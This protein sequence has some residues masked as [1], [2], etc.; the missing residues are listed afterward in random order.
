MRIAVIGAGALGTFFAA[1]LAGAGHDVGM[2]A[3][4]ARLDSIRRDGLQLAGSNP[5]HVPA[6]ADL[7]ALPSPD[8]VLIATKTPALA[9]AIA[10]QVHCNA[11]ANA[12]LTV[13]NGV[14]APDQVAAAL[15]QAAVLAGRVHGFFELEQDVVRH[16]GVPPSLA[17]APWTATAAPAAQLLAQALIDAGI[18][19]EQPADIAAALWEKLLLVSTIGG[20]GAALGLPI[21]A[22]RD[23]PAHAATLTA[24]MHEVAA[25]A[26]A[27]G[28]TLPADC[29]ARTLAFVGT[30]PAEATASLHRD[31]AARQ[32]SEFD[33]LTGAIPRLAA[34]VGMP[35]PIHN[36]IIAR[37]SA[38]GLI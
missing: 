29:V 22:I 14:E 31:L 32:P 19:F 13:Q 36:A 20:L 24:A 1:R 2:V 9:A 10:L 35:V 25:L 34:A 37:L 3:R 30:F 4:G 26:A 12:V 8:L 18:A 11:T 16:V 27:R 17:F 38:Q 28:V 6:D 5:V 21:G 15:P 23:N 33:A 7:A